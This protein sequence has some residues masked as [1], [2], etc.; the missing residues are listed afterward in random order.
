MQAL[1]YARQ[2]GD[3]IEGVGVSKPPCAPC[4]QQLDRQNVEHDHDGDGLQSPRN[5]E[6]PENIET[7]AFATI[8]KRKVKVE[9]NLW[10]ISHNIPKNMKGKN[11]SL[12]I[13]NYQT[14]TQLYMFCVEK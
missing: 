5:W 3:S 9:G 2:T 11:I 10:E 13:E 4:E 6:D 1:A 7:E 14:F 8:S 12:N